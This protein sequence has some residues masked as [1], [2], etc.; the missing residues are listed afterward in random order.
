VKKILLYCLAAIFLI[1]TFIISYKLLQN[2]TSIVPFPYEFIANKEKI[3]LEKAPILIIGDSMGVKLSNFKK[4]LSQK[5]SKNMSKPIRIHSLAKNG[6]GIHRTLETIKSLGQL[7]LI[8]IYIGNTDQSVEKIFRYNDIKTIEQNM[9]LYNNPMIQSVLMAFPVLSR[10]LYLPVKSVKLGDKIK[11]AKR[12]LPDALYQLIMGLKFKLYE[13]SVAE[14]F[15]YSTKN[16]SFIIPITTPLNLK[17]K[18]SKSCYAS[19]DPST[20]TDLKSLKKKL[21]IRDFKGAYNLSHDMALINS[22]HASSLFLHGYTSL[23]LNKFKESQ[24]YFEQSMAFDCKNFTGSPVFNEILKKQANL[25]GIQYLDFHQY[26]VDQSYFNHTFFD[27]HI[28]QNF[29]MEK[30]T[31][32][33]ALRIKTLLKLN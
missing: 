16:S 11:R 29:Y 12:D 21:K 30:L 10:L 19:L 13:A 17:R 25:R 22:T 20:K 14:L 26:L 8:I 33:L 2:K 24:K 1:P 32:M 15:K 3:D 31:D 27:D 7:P 4:V 28:P 23:K 6:A 18:P 9:K 5:I